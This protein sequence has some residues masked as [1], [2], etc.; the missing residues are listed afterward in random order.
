MSLLHR[1]TLQISR[2]FDGRGAI[3]AETHKDGPPG[4]RKVRCN[5]RLKPEDGHIAVVLSEEAR[6]PK[7]TWER[8]ERHMSFSLGETRAGGVLKMTWRIG[9][10]VFSEADEALLRGEGE[11]RGRIVASGGDGG[12][13]TEMAG[14]PSRLN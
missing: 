8:E 4:D 13:A 1:T 12:H 7:V 6:G 11:A 2:D 3:W 5:I 10:S 14:E 9:R